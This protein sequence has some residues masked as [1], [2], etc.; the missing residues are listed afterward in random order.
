[1]L[2]FLKRKFKIFL[3]SNSGFLI[4]LAA[5][6]CVG[7]FLWFY[8]T[9]PPYGSINNEL[10]NHSWGII[11]DIAHKWR[12]ID[13]S[14]WDRGIGGGTCLF[15]SGFYP[16]FNPTNVSALFINDD[17]FFKFKIIEPYVAGVFFAVLVL[18]EI[19]A[20][21]WAYAVF[22]GLL[23]MGLGFGRFATLSDAPYFLWG[24]ALFP[25]LVYALGKFEDRQWIL[26]AAVAGLVLSTQFLVEGASQFFQIF[27]WGLVFFTVQFFWLTA[28]RGLSKNLCIRWIVSCCLFCFFATALCAIQFLPTFYFS[29]FDSARPN[30]GQ[31]S[32]NNFPIFHRAA[33]EQKGSVFGFFCRLIIS[34]GGVSWRAIIALWFLSIGLVV[35]YRT[36]FKKFFQQYPILA[37]LCIA[38]MIHFL[39]PTIAGWLAVSSPLLAKLLRFFSFVTFAY[40][41]HIIDFCAM[42]VLVFILSNGE[43]ILERKLNIFHLVMCVFAAFFVTLPLIIANPYLKNFLVMAW[44]IL[45]GFNPVNFKSAAL[46]FFLG[47][48][49]ILYYGF[50]IQQKFIRFLVWG[51]LVLLGFMTMILSFNWN[52]KGQRTDVISYAVDSPEGQYFRNAGGKFYLPFDELFSVSHNFNLLYNV[53]G[54]SGFLQVPPKRFNQ[55]MAAYHNQLIEKKEFRWVPKYM[56]INPSSALATRFPVDFTTVRKDCLLNWSGFE[57]KISG[58]NFDIWE[59]NGSTEHVYFADTLVVQEYA[60]IVAAYDEPFGHVVRVEKKDASV[61]CV[62]EKK[63]LSFKKDKTTGY[64]FISRSAD[65]MVF[66]ISSSSDIFVIVP[67]IFQPGWK[68]FV[69]GKPVKIFPAD[70][71]FIGFEL[72]GGQHAI[73]VKFIPPYFWIGLMISLFSTVLLG[74]G[75]Y[76]KRWP[77][78]ANKR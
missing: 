39:L 22:G 69:D 51:M 65:E 40:S 9:L 42:L 61:F 47:A 27:V 35:S 13:L 36:H 24:C 25:A 10:S 26:T 49:L 44:P 30:A 70:A 5:A 19:F 67:E 17:M 45:E 63:L 23:Y 2:D 28:E 31:Y 46:V 48:G 15:S 58:K 66:K 41:V 37:I 14:F 54:T 55:F 53:R 1:M 18:F 56:I 76:S 77:G 11:V 6:F 29:F 62:T 50:N 38:T 71:L 7:I 64:D 52:N 72:A 59:R 33:V 32:I 57:K 73:K 3:K 16:I 60:K 75:L 68:V 74:A 4:A 21:R 20:L 78:K 43:K 8:S 34:P 12:S